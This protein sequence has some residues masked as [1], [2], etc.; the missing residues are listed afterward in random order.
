MGA[1]ATRYRVSAARD[2]VRLDIDEQTFWDNTVVVAK[3]GTT[4]LDV[5]IAAVVEEIRAALYYI[6]TDG[7]KH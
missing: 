2:E 5:N 7:P 3:D 1:K 6:G 4:Q